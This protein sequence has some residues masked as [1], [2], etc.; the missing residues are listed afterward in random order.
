M[1]GHFPILEHLSL[2]SVEDTITTI[3]LPK[4]FLAPKLRHLDIPGIGRP[5]K[6]LRLLTSTLSLG[7]LVLWNM[8]TSSYF[9]PRLLVARLSCLPQLKKLTI[10]FSIPIPRP[11]TE[12]EL[13]GE[14]GT[15]VTLPNLANLTL[16]GVSAYLESFLAQI[17]APLLER[18]D[19][20][21]FNQITFALPHLSHCINTTEKLKL[22]SAKV[23]FGKE[24]VFIVSLDR[25]SVGPFR[26][27]V[28]C[29]QLDWQVHCAAQI[30]NALIPAL[31]SV[32]QIVLDFHETVLPTEWQNGEI[33]STTWHELLRPFV[34]M[35]ELHIE[36]GLSKELSSALGEVGSDPWFLPNL[37]Q[38]FAEDNLFALFIDTRQVMGRPI[39]FLG[40]TSPAFPKLIRNK[41]PPLLEQKH[42]LFGGGR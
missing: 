41:R 32:E 13:L 6:R 8:Q 3:T 19:I 9:R 36:D 12:R 25:R 40:P 21:F 31:S 42:D 23:F 33:N 26:L 22:P 29:T 16:R 2:W 38:I 18:F 1:D 28:R 4:A 17:R 30:C 24:E 34:G 14:H 35:K 10:G 5:P 15:P 37:Q 11:G 27:C 20:T 39:Q 7:S